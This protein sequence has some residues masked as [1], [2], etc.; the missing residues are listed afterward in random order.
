MTPTPRLPDY[1]RHMQAA[2]QQ[3]LAY[4]AGM[5]LA[6]FMADFRTQHAVL[7][8]FVILGEASAKLM[9]R[10]PDFVVQHPTVPWRAI[11]NMRNQLAHGYFKVDNER[12]WN[13]VIGALPEL[14][15]QLPAV[16]AAAD[17]QGAP[18][19]ATEPDS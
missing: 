17:L 1:L 14:L 12:L 11:R 10:Y 19:S 15:A 9:D 8:N 13:T 16:I 7:F 4:T 6:A 5:D 3:T 18:P 2:A